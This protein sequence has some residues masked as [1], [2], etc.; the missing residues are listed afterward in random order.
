MDMHLIDAAGNVISSFGGAGGTSA[1]DDADFTRAS[2][3]GTPVMGVYES[4]PGAIT[5]GDMG[6]VAVD[7]NGRWKVL[8]DGST[9]DAANDAV[10]SGNPV[11]IG[12]QARTSFPT[13]VANADR[14]NANGTTLGQQWVAHISPEQQVTKR[15]RYTTAQAA[16]AAASIWDPTSGKRIAITHI[17]IGTGGTTA[18]RLILFFAANADLTYTEGTDQLVFDGTLTPTSTATPG[19]IMPF[20]P[21][22]FCQTADFELKAQTDANLTVAISVLGYEW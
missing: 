2:T 13:A 20:N 4:A 15:A 19:A 22:C 8:L 1:T 18:A 3:I 16:G 11:K 7:Q 10:D 17:N 6:I 14:V 21:P 12:M 5:D 9:L